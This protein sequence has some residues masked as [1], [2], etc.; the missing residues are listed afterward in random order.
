[1][2]RQIPNAITVARIALVVPIG[3]AIMTRQNELALI[4]AAVAGV[5]DAFDGFLARQF[6]WQTRL[7]AWLDPAA[8][9]LMLVTAYVCLGTVAA[10]PWWLVAL[11]LARDVVLVAG[12]L[13]LRRWRGLREVRPSRLSKY[14]TLVQIVCVLAVL[15]DLHG[16]PALALQ[17]LMWLV[18]VLTVASGV[19]YVLRF[20]ARA[21][22]Q[23][24][25]E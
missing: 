14:N 6:G 4:L 20:A 18:A 21:R 22:R 7:G 3:W 8:D 25:H 23:G 11:V 2:L 12:V 1:M 16:R 24:K 9:K 19:D 17:P 10:L 13:A 15:F 5:S